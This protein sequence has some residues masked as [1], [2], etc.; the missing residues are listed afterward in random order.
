MVGEVLV[1]L[2]QIEGGGRSEATMMQQ[3]KAHGW[4]RLPHSGSK[5]LHSKAANTAE[6]ST[7][8]AIAP[9]TAALIWPLVLGSINA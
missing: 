2:S 1:R 7:M 4:L 8:T 9:Q 3:R 6:S 5:N